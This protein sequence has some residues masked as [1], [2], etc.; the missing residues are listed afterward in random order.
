MAPE[1]WRAS[2]PTARSD[3]YSLG[4]VL[5]ELG[6]GRAPYH[7]VPVPELAR[8]VQD[9]DAPPLGRRRRGSIRAFAAIV[10]RCLRA[11]P[12]ERFA[13]ADEL[14]DALEEL[15]AARPAAP[16]PGRQPVPRPAPFEAEHR[17]LFFGRGREIGAVIDR[18]RAEPFVLVAGD[19]GV[20]KSSL[21]R[22]G[23]LP[24]VADGALGGGRTW[25][26]RAAHARAAAAAR[27]GRR[28]RPARS[29]STRTP[30]LELLTDRARRCATRLRAALGEER[31]LVL[32]VDQLEELVTLT[33]PDEARRGRARAGPLAAGVPGRA[34]CSPT[35]RADFLRASPRC[36]ALGDDLARA[37]FFLRPLGRRPHPRGDRRARRRPPAFAS[38]PR[39]WST[40]WSTPARDGARAA[41]R[42]CSSR[43][44][45]CGRRATSS[46]A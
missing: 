34:R 19:S 16:R 42:S 20:G 10:D 1:V 31:G 4:A 36:P 33:E 45:S 44:P 29:T 14:R 12:G 38:S 9:R 5:Y 18:L 11:R 30:P 25:T 6:A 21:C 40:S 13:S 26:G 17:A 35:V 24:A 8:V 32:F 15:R 3:V 46:A 7:D 39:R 23:V 22:A 43:W 27:A 37:L 28:A 2:R 41:C